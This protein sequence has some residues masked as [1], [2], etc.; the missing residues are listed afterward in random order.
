MSV[1]N[2]RLG[3][4][5]VTYQADL[6]NVYNSDIGNH[7]KVGTF[8]EIGG[9][10]IGEGTVISAFCFICSG[11]TIGKNC[12][13]GPRT[14]FLNDTYPSIKDNFVPEIT[15]VEDDVIIGGCV[16]VLPGVHIGKGAKIAAGAVVTSDVA[17]GTTVLGFPARV[18]D[19]VWNPMDAAGKLDEPVFCEEKSVFPKA[20]QDHCYNNIVGPGSYSEEY[21][22]FLETGSWEKDNTLAERAAEI[23][24]EYKDKVEDKASVAI[25]YGDCLNCGEPS[26]IIPKPEVATEDNL[27]KI[28]YGELVDIVDEEHPFRNKVVADIMKDGKIDFSNSM[29]RGPIY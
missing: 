7:V 21:K 25:R 28:T 26:S 1:V 15:T 8:T 2:S 10:V 13:V 17:A 23:I 12:F 24:R 4:Q 5:V 16:T 11:V 19:D 14:T 29:F 3:T 20:L 6:I 22:K 27:S 9:A 18:R